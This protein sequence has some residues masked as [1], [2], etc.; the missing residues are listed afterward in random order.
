MNVTIAFST[1]QASRLLLIGAT[2]SEKVRINESSFERCLGL[3]GD[4]QTLWVA[5]LFQIWRL[6]NPLMPS[7][8]HKHYDRVY[9]L[10]LGL[11]DRQYRCAR[12]RHQLRG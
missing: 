3:W 8:M 10:R 1:Y 5:T 11:C 7:M 12:S 4:G 6:D 9:V 2:Q